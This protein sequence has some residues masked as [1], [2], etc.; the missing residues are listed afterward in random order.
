MYRSDMFKTIPFH[1]AEHQKKRLEA[2]ELM[3]MLQELRRKAEQKAPEE[4]YK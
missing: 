1:V 2:D 3:E 4:K